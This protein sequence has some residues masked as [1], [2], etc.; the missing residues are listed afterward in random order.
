MPTTPTRTSRMTPLLLLSCSV[1]RLTVSGHVYSVSW[2]DSALHA[3]PTN[4]TGFAKSI[5]KPIPS[6]PTNSTPPIEFTA[7]Q[8]AT[9]TALTPRSFPLFVPH[10][11]VDGRAYVSWLRRAPARLQAIPTPSLSLS[12]LTYINVCTL[13]LRWCVAA[14][15][16]TKGWA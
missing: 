6:T 10:G 4:L 8:F 1:L 16:A 7:D 15:R 12:T 5:S 11:H 3:N 2:L 13:L 9:P 14:L